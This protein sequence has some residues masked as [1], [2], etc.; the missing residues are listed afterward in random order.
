MRVPLQILSLIALLLTVHANAQERFMV[1]TLHASYKVEHRSVIRSIGKLESTS[2]IIHG[3]VSPMGEGDPVRWSQGLPGVT[4]GADGSSAIYVRGGNVGNNLFSVDGVPVYGYS[5][6]LGMTTAI[7]SFVIQSASLSKGGFEGRYGNFTAS[8]LNVITREPEVGRTHA[9]GTINTF[10]A[11]ASMESPIR[12]DMSIIASA[13]FS[14]LGLEYKALKNL[15]PEHL[16]SIQDIRTSVGDLY[17]KFRWTIDS[18]SSLTASVILSLDRYGFSTRDDSMDAIGWDNQIAIV[19]YHRN[20]GRTEMEAQA[21]INR[22]GSM[23]RQ[24]KMYHGTENRLSL[25]SS[26]LESALSADLSTGL[27]SGWKLD[28]GVKAR[29]GMFALGPASN[30]FEKKT[31]LAST[32][33]QASFDI[34]DRFL[35][36]AVLRENCYYNFSDGM[37]NFSPDASIS[38]RW[39]IVGALAL[40]GYADYIHQYYHTLE[41]LPL[42][43]S[44]DVIVPSGRTAESEVAYQGNLGFNLSLDRHFVLLGG[45]YKRM[46]NLVFYK[47]AQTLFSDAIAGWEHNIDLGSGNSFGTE[48]LYEYTGRDVYFRTAYTLSKT[49]REGFKTIYDGGRF[50]A[51]FDRRH[52]LNMQSRWKG[53]NVALTLQSGHWENAAPL[54]YQIHIPGIDTEAEYYEGAN[55]YH[56]PT[57]FRADVGYEMHF[58]TGKASHDV[59]IGVCNLTNHFNPFMLYFDASTETWKELALLPILPNFSWRVGF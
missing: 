39:N 3:V 32:Y 27:S 1:D 4:T 15:L 28:Y 26:M 11:G 13:R 14:P 10:L 50:H 25:L 17:S 59:S 45:Y 40:E 46:D 56:M 58:R 41:G 16:A 47:Y 49:N 23:Q 12:R 44:S 18:C 55:N 8:H 2:G 51:R 34:H 20:S 9:E 7:P 33:A 31:V 48:F 21:Y 38:L 42:G 22:C 57:V 52:L 24:E 6:I 30:H 35:M 19:K 36:N 43:W 5:H 37:N 54:K 53:F 29:Y